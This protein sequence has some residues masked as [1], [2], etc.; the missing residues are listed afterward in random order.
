MQRPLPSTDWPR[1]DRLVVDRAGYL[2]TEKAEVPERLIDI[3]EREPERV[4][5]TEALRYVQVP[6]PDVRPLVEWLD[7]ARR[8]SCGAGSRREILRGTAARARCESDRRH[9]PSRRSPM[10]RLA[11][12]LGAA[13]GA[14]AQLARLSRP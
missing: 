14:A 7:A 6:R 4:L 3:A 1:P 5:S 8:G 12:Y 13:I 9:C 11:D 10:R 2:H